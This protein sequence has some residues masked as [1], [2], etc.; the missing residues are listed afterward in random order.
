[1][2]LSSNSTHRKEMERLLTYRKLLTVCPLFAPLCFPS[3]LPIKPQS[4]RPTPKHTSTPGVKPTKLSIFSSVLRPRLSERLMTTYP[5]TSSWLFKRA[6]IP[7]MA[8]STST[9]V[10]C[11]WIRSARMRSPRIVPTNGLRRSFS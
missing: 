7:L 3:R 4:Q 10:F 2:F 6:S 5:N 8:T 9:F 11:I 1:M